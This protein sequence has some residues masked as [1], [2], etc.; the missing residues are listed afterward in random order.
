MVNS[1]LVKWVD[2]KPYTRNLIPGE[3]IYWEVHRKINGIDYRYWD[4]K[5][6]KL[7]AFLV[8]KGKTFPF[9]VKTS[10]LYLGAANGTTVSHISDMT[11]A[12]KIFA[13]EVA[14]NPFR[15]LLA[16]AEKRGNI[17]PIL[18][19]ANH[20]EIYERLVGQVDI[21]YQDISQRNQTEIFIR[22]SRM[23]KSGGVGYLMLK[24]RCIDVTASP[25]KMFEECR[26]DIE[27][28]G[29]KI[30]EMVRLDPY[31]KDHAA[32]VVSK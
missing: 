9:D 28:A 15:E 14:K 25:I 30:L 11:P 18:E 2:S 1:M 7:A 16:L 13:V 32:F 26:K 10:V 21:M 23:L 19:D 4:P 6:S 29:F 31:E 5:R 3:S 24:A 22:N 8:C 17:I 27:N 20:P 12:G